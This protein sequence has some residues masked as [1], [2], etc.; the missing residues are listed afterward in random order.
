MNPRQFSPLQAGRVAALAAM[1]SYGAGTAAQD[2]TF[3]DGPVGFDR[4]LDDAKAPWVEGSLVLPGW[5]GKTGSLVELNVG[6]GGMPYRIYI[7][8]KSLSTGKDRVVRY[9]VVIVSTSGV[10][11]VTYEGLHC[12]ERNYRRLAVGIDGKW[13]PLKDPEWRYISGIGMDR[14]RKRLY[15]D[16]FCE[17]DNRYLEADELLRRLTFDNDPVIADD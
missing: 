14:Y 13:R 10:R 7:D 8:P 5:P 12:G 4:G 16:Y 6:R 1:L 2:T 15:E 17:T 11:N 3:E 9:T